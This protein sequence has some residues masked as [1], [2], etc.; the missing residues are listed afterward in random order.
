MK[1][2]KQ[3]NLTGVTWLCRSECLNSQNYLAD[4]WAREM[5]LEVLEKAREKYHFQLIDMELSGNRC[6]LTIQT[7]EGATPI[8]P[9]M[10]YIKSRIAERYNRAMKRTGP[11]WN[12]RSR[13]RLLEKAVRPV[14]PLDREAFMA[15]GI[16]VPLFAERIA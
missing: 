2:L 11:F 13:Y 8:S 9:I 12:S 6:D 1:Q 7:G 10:Q 16:A 14:F 4:A 3:N 5:V 15:G